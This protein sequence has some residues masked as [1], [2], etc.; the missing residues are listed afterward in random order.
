[1]KSL[2]IDNDRAAAL[3]QAFRRRPGVAAP[4]ARA[5]GCDRRTAAKAWSKGFQRKGIKELYRRPFKDI[6]AEEQEE[7]RARIQADETAAE[8][9]ATAVEVQ[10]RGVARTDAIEDLTEERVQEAQL[11]RQARA[12]TIILLTTVTQ[13]AAGLNKLAAKIK[14]ALEEAAEGEVGMKE[15]QQAMGLMAK[16]TTSLRQC[17]DAGQRAME[18]SR[19]LLGEPQRI[20]GHAHLESLTMAEARARVAAAQRALTTA[21]KA[22]ST[23]V[24]AVEVGVP[25]LN[26]GM[27]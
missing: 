22:G 24:E 21:E 27:H 5:A 25:G 19:L 11:V 4:A 14:V 13:T 9:L 16:L 10:R 3:L 17:N 2:R 26:P 8:K 6:L 20:I 1:M 15:A 18:M 12:G 23:E 7:I